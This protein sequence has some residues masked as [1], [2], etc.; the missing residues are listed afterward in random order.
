[1]FQNGTEQRPTS[2][3]EVAERRGATRRS[4]VERIA[5]TTQWGTTA[6]SLLDL[7][8]TGAQVRFADGLVPFEGDDVMLRLV[9]G[10]HLSGSIAWSVRDAL[11]IAF[12]QPLPELDDILWLE[13]RAPDWFHASVRAQRQ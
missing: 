11:G 6:A 12:E 2:A 1:M 8:E 4:H 13:L 5:L 7:S 9:D 10:R 3:P